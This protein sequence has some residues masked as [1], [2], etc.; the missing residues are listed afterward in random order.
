MPGPQGANLQ[1][2]NDLV[3]DKV[4][5]AYQ[6]SFIAS[7]EEAAYDT[8]TVNGVYRVNGAVYLNNLTLA[9]GANL[10]LGDDANITLEAFN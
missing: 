8:L 10:I 9:D 6:T 1:V 4:I 7:G 2:D 5:N 3:N